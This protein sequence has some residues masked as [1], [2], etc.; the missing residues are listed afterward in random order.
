VVESSGYPLLFLDVDG[1]LIP[2]G[3]IGEHDSEPRGEGRDEANPLL[4][5]L[6]PELG[7]LLSSLRCELIWTTTWSH[8]ANRHIGPIL[9]LPTLTVLDW[10]DEAAD[11]I[12]T[13]FGLHWKTRAVVEHA[14][15]RTFIWIDDEITDRDTEWVSANHPGRALLHRVDSRVG[16][17]PSDF[18]VLSAWLGAY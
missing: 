10:P 12:D 15:G 4:A 8:D 1:P 5:R 11:P 16:L 6:D 7:P 13:W 17:R 18:D 2:F 3:G 14:A 9:G